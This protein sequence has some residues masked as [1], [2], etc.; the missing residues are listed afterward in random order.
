MRILVVDD[1]LIS[2]LA[3]S[4]TLRDEGYEVATANSG[5]Q[6]IELGQLFNPDVLICDWY[7]EDSYTGL[8]VANSLSIINTS[9]KIIIITGSSTEDIEAS[10]KN[11]NICKIIEKPYD[12]D[13]LLITLKT[14]IEKQL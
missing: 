8:Q 12:I 5:K 11:V 1:E 3:L 6:A 9:L 4:I 7:L 2:T 14:I 13:K 10:L